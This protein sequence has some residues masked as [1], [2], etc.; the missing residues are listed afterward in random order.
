[1][2]LRAASGNLSHEACAQAS[3]RRARS[4]RSPPSASRLNPEGVRASDHP[5]RNRTSR[6]RRARELERLSSRSRG[7]SKRDRFFPFFVV[8]LSPPSLNPFFAPEPT[9]SRRPSAR[10]RAYEPCR[11]RR[12][13]F[14]SA[15]PARGG[16]GAVGIPD[17]R[18]GAPRS[19]CRA[20]AGHPLTYTLWRPLY[21]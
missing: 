18:D 15:V 20:T 9:P 2:R 7:V 8:F 21:I 12:P 1:M 14:S 16:V 6:P 19:L 4:V 11:A 17:V 10:C 5:K 3:F 13:G